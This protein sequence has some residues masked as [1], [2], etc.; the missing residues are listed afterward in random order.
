MTPDE[1]VPKVYT[2]TGDDGSTGML[3]GG[4]RQGLQ[5]I[6]AELRVASTPVTP[7]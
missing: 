4:R 2:K 3:F 5:H 6:E 1:D 7:S